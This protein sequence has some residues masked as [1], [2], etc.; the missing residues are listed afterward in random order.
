MKIITFQEKDYKQFDSIE[1]AERYREELHGNDCMDNLRFCYLP[2]S[3][4]G[5]VGDDYET[6]ENCYQEYLGKKE[7]G[8]CGFMDENIFI[9][10]NMAIIGCNFGH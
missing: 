2:F 8:C 4:G 5:S 7:D 1:E 9:E 3:I 10:N 6:M